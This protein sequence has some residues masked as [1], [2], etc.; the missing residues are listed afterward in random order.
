MLEQLIKDAI[1]KECRKT[2][3]QEVAERA[4]I[5]QTH[6]NGLLNGRKSVKKMS[7]DTLARLFPDLKISLHGWEESG[8]VLSTIDQKIL[9]FIQEL[10]DEVKLD[11]FRTL[12]ENFSDKKPVKKQKAG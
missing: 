5:S 12:I 7:I 4:G 11:V 9:S 8:A 2:T 6:I 10:D 3:Q 1:R